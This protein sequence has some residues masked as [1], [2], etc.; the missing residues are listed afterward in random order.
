MTKSTA[1]PFNGLWRIVP[2]PE[3]QQSVR[4]LVEERLLTIAEEKGL[5]RPELTDDCNLLDCVD[6]LG[7]MEL[8]SSV[9][10]AIGREVDLSEYEVETFTTL[11]G[12][13]KAVAASS[14]EA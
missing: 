14:G 10:S 7:F 4:A 6:S 5:P 8:I 2:M 12:F 11:G 13:V 1:R 9:E 3:T